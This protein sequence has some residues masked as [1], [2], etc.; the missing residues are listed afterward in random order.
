M[1]RRKLNFHTLVKC[2]SALKLFTGLAIATFI[3]W[4]LTV[5][6]AISRAA[7]AAIKYI[8]QLISVL[9][10]KSCSHLVIA[11]YDNGKAI[12]QAI[13]TSFKNSLESILETCITLAP[14]TLRIP[15]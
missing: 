9:Y 15:I 10:A 11:Q 8:H 1:G 3:A 13:N 2:Y 7:M 4:K 5:I 6:N 12:K 14:T